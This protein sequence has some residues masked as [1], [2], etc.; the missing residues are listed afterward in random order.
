[1]K[2]LYILTA[3]LAAFACSNLEAQTT[4]LEAKIPFDFNV[5]KT[6]MPAGAYRITYS[7]H[8]MTMQSEVGHHAVNVL[9][10]PKDRS[11][12]KT[13]GAVEFRC[14]GSARFFSG[15]WAPNSSSGEG[16]VPG[17]TEKELASRVAV[18]PEVVALNGR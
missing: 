15:I 1:M 3:L 18:Q 7:N 13:E 17:R 12:R 6:A 16:L 5:G 11:V 8:V 14:Y 4:I 10:L 9:V 2:R